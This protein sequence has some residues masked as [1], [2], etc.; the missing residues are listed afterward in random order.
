MIYSAGAVRV[1]VG[2]ASVKGVSGSEQFATN[3]A[4]GYLFK[5]TDESSWYQIAAIT[6]A[7]NFTLSA[8][9]S[10]S[11]YKTLR[12]DEHSATMTTATKMYSG[13]LSYYPVI[14][15]AITITASGESFVDDGGGVL[16]GNA[17]PAG[18]GTIDYDTGAWTITLGTD[19]T[20]TAEM[21]ASYYSGDTRNGMSYQI[22]TDYTSYY[23]IPEMSLNDINFPHIYTKAMRII[24]S[25]INSI[26]ATTITK[27]ITN[28]S[29]A[30]L[31]TIATT[32]LSKIHR[33]SNTETCYVTFPTITSSQTGK[34]I[35]IRKKGTGEID[36]KVQGNNTLD[37]NATHVYNNNASQTNA[38]LKL[39]I[40]NATNFEFDTIIGDWSTY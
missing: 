16:S 18:S 26:S 27:T 31:V 3:A 28:H 2:S 29:T 20:A 6:N 19:L 34:W 22:I 10:N 21:T 1:K 36:C 24:D 12:S 11:S 17:S 7:T 33:F 13:T 9:Y 39:S 8:R 40:E 14:Q 25:S 37:G 30:T 23:S 38:L 5:I 4:A 32:N 15:N 35:W